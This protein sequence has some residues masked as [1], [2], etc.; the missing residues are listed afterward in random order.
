MELWFFMEL[1]TAYY[2]LRYGSY[3]T[4]GVAFS[5]QSSKTFFWSSMRRVPWVVLT[6][7]FVSPNVTL[8]I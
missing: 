1:V 6:S 7:H 5:S 8:L 3:Y 4:Y 2:T